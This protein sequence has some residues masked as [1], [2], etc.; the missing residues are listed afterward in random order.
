MTFCSGYF[1]NT[2]EPRR[3]GITNVNG[4]VYP[5][6][7]A[8]MVHIS[9]SI[10]LTNTLLVPSLSNKLLFVSQVTE[11]LNCIALMYPKF[12][13]FRIF[14]RRRSLGVVLRERGY[15]TWM[16]SILAESTP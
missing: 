7:E 4:V 6:T 12:C 3:T 16:T 11:D 10:S 8:G 14:S 15:T 2:T 1:A 13:L 5:I 9:P